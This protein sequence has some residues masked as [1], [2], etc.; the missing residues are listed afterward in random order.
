[1][2]TLLALMAAAFLAACTSVPVQ[3]PPAGD[4]EVASMLESALSSA[5]A[6]SPGTRGADAVM[7]PAKASGPSI[8]IKYAGDARDLLRQVS[9]SRDLRFAVR[10]PQPHLP[11]FVIV[12]VRDVSFEEFLTDVGSQLGQRADLVLTDKSIEVRYRGQ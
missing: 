6:Q 7:K 5:Q 2:K 3:A 10:G 8:A 12:D 9:A 4:K 11:L 1:M